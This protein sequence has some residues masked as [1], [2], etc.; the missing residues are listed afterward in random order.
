VLVQV[1]RAGRSESGRTYTLEAINDVARLIDRTVSTPVHIG[2]PAD[3][4]STPY[5]GRIC[6]PA[7][8]VDGAVFARLFGLGE[9]ELVDMYKNALARG[10]GSLGLSVQGE[11]TTHA[12]TREVVSFDILESVDFD[13]RSTH[14]AAGGQVFFSDGL[15]VPWTE[16]E[17][18]R[19]ATQTRRVG[20]TPAPTSAARVATPG[21]QQ[22]AM[23]EAEIARLLAQTTIDATVRT[24]VDRAYA[25]IMQRRTTRSVFIKEE[26]GGR[27]LGPLVS[28]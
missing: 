1:I 27:V 16:R 20:A 24:A 28:V 2:H 7:E 19:R 8:V 17:T 4:P 18:Y 22:I 5:I 11:G 10:Y 21:A 25:Q 13:T 3:N 12:T 14:A 26:A 23:L 6:G 15:P 9:A